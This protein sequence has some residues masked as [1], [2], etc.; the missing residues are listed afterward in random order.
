MSADL[1]IDCEHCSGRGG[2]MREMY[3]GDREWTP[4]RAC[5]GTGEVPDRDLVCVECLDNDGDVIAA[6]ADGL[7]A[8]CLHERDARAAVAAERAASIDEHGV[9]EH[10]RRAVRVGRAS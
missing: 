3:P 1:T 9:L 4:C 6:V 2:W 7:C 10:Y 8:D 5:R